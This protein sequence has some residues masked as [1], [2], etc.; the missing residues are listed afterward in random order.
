[1]GKRSRVENNIIALWQQSAMEAGKR[2]G[3]KKAYKFAA[4]VMNKVRRMLCDN[5]VARDLHCSLD[6]NGI[7]VQKKRER[8]ESHKQ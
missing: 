8:K 6:A 1:M 3:Y 4:T 5:S 7:S 2:N